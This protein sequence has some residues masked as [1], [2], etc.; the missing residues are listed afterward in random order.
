M[1]P[2]APARVGSA[3]ARVPTLLATIAI[4]LG[5]CTGSGVATSTPSSPASPA[6][7]SPS[8]AVA[9]ATPAI[10]EVPMPTP[11]PS[12]KRWNLVWSDEFDEPAGTVPDPAHWRH[13]LGDGTANGIPGWGNQELESY[14]DRPE[15]VSTDGKGNLAFH[16][17]VADGSET[18]YYGPCRYTSAKILTKG[19]FEPLYGRIE[20]R[21]KVPG[22]YGLWPAFWLLGNDIEQTPWPACGE[23]DVMEFV[24]QRPNEILGT[25]HGPG[26]SGSSGFTKTLQLGKPVADEF[27]VFAIEWGPGWISWLLDGVEYHHATPADVAPNRWVFD[28]PFYLVLNVAVGGN[29]GGLV[30]PETTFPQTMLVDYVRIY[31]GAE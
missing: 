14:G 30:S 7:P 11:A 17:R 23:I 5:G 13:D 29:L 28:H 3:G 20:A 1:T 26:Y 15:D 16:I 31:E 4:L 21:I 10:T 9:S 6:T 2:P 12:P 8:P 25:I 22:G 19:R 24:G 27:H 18:C